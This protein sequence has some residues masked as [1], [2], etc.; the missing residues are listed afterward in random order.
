MNQEMMNTK[1]VAEYLN[2]NEKKVYALIKEGEIPCTKITGKWIFPKNL[3]DKWIEDSVQ[4]TKALEGI[5]NITIIGSH[6]LSIDLLASEVNKKFPQLILLSANLGSIG[7]LIS[8]KRGRSHIAGAHL[9][10]PETD[11]YNLPYLPK[12]LPKLESVVVN[13]VYR[14]QGLIVQPGN[15]LN[16]SGFEHLCHPNVRFINRQEGAGTRLLL[17]YHL[18]QLGI[19]GNQIRGYNH[20]VSTHTEVATAIRNE[21]ADVGLGVLSAAMSFGLEFIPITKERFDLIIPKAYFYTEPIQEL[22]EIVRSENFIHKVEQMGGYDIKDT[23]KVL[24]WR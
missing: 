18:K 10:H 8:L 3:I 21:Q 6:D 7:G 9:F 14:E 19:E 4:G 20:Q 5:E 13:F 15:P 11:E 1:E 12:Y 24:V 22:L 17:D 16:I 2:L 23:G